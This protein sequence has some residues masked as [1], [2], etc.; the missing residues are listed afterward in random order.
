MI[1][2]GWGAVGPSCV[3]R[4]IKRENL[5]I[6]D[7]KYR[8]DGCNKQGGEDQVVGMEG[9][10]N[11]NG[12]A[13]ARPEADAAAATYDKEAANQGTSPGLLP[14]SIQAAC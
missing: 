8:F 12:S 9:V 1:A 7:D 6:P 3:D 13:I 11:G 10:D 2:L 5:V 4:A 14:P